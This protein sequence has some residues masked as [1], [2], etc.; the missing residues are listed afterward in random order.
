MLTAFA[1]LTTI[2][3]ALQRPSEIYPVE[4][5]A[6][7]L[8]G[9]IERAREQA[10]AMEGEALV[11]IVPDGRYAVRAGAR[12]TLAL[13]NTAAS[14]WEALPDG[15][16]WGAGDAVRDPAGQPV[17]AIPAQVFCDADGLCASPPPA[18]VYLLRSVRESHRVAA[19]TLDASG[20]VQT[21]RWVR[22]DG[23]WTP[24]AR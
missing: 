1:I 12:G 4:L 10:V 13:T 8:A 22:G 2:Y 21:W 14:E 20:S 5:A 9:E 6:Q 24:V 7:R 15:L 23:S 19:V 17:G 18:A 16:A 3:M 11:A